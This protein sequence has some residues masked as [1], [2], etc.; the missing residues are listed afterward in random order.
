[1]NIK[2]L[3]GCVSGLC[4]L[5]SA[6][7]AEPD[8]KGVINT[9]DLTTGNISI[10]YRNMHLTDTTQIRSAEGRSKDKDDLATRQ[11]VSYSVNESGD[12]TEIHIYDPRKLKEQRFYT[13]N[14]LDH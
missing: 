4:L 1:M 5:S 2:L 9:L 11:H 12:I 8:N 13:G 7:I 10:N 3:T 6:A 14:E